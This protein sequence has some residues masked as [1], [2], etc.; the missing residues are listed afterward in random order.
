MTG[1]LLFF[2]AHNETINKASNKSTGVGAKNFK[3]AETCDAL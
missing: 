2:C 3:T 1:Q